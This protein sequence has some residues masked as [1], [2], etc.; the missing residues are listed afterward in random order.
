MG[1]QNQPNPTTVRKAQEVAEFW[2]GVS[3]GNGLGVLCVSA[4]ALGGLSLKG[5]QGLGSRACGER[6]S[7][8]E[9]LACSLQP[10]S[11]RLEFGEGSRDQRRVSRL[12]VAMGRASKPVGRC[13]PG[14]QAV[15]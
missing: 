6:A 2:A 7:M 13:G 12:Q 9:S 11:G 15:V 10:S 3:K 14:S 1:K 8:C 4:R 5:G